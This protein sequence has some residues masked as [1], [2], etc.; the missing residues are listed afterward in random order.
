[1]SSSLIPNTIRSRLF[2]VTCPSCNSP[3][4]TLETRSAEGGAAVRRRREC[5]HCG[6]RF[7]SFERR[8][9]EPGFVL[10]RGG[11]REPFDPAKLRAALGRA[12]HKRPVG[13]AELDALVGRIE[14]EVERAG[15]ELP[16]E[17]LRELCLEGLGSLDAGAF[18]Q[19]AGVELSDPAEV[20]TALD[21]LDGLEA[22]KDRDF[23]PL[24][25]VGSVRG[26]EEARRPTQR[27]GSRGDF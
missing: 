8:E 15:G 25:G 11:R 10:K 7:T 22:R 26:E 6:R 18:L 3:T 4:R 9:R 20:R 12:A 19:F 5:K 21:R 16:S 13:G 1:V 23:S 14:A 24:A 2:G 27:D 17:A